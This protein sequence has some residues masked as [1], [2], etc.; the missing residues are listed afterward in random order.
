[1]DSWVSALC[2][3]LGVPVDDV[4][5]GGILDLARDAAHTVERPAAPVTAFIAGY[6]AATKGGG[7]AAVNAA[8]DIAGELARD[9]ND[10]PDVTTPTLQ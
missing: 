7:A 10:G 4:D 2:E 8:L 3:R 6:A 5:V 1:M 9:W